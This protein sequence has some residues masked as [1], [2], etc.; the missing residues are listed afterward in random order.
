MT[1]RRTTYPSVVLTS[2]FASMRVFHLRINEHCL[3]RVSVMAWK[4]VRQLRPCT[5]SMQSLTFLNDWSSSALR[6]ARLSSKTLPFISSVAIFVPC[7]LEMSVLPQLRTLK[8][9]G[10]LISYHSFLR[11]GSPCFFLPP[12]LPPFVNLLFLPTAICAEPQMF[13]DRILSQN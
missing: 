6:S 3:S 9:E 7:V 10:A 2:T 8:A 5:S 4:S 1:K 13:L 12:F 11:K